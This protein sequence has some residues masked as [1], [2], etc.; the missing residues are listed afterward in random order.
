MKPEIYFKDVELTDLTKAVIKSKWNDAEDRVDIEVFVEQS[1]SIYRGSCSQKSLKEKEAAFE[2]IKSSLTSQEK[3]D[4]V[5]FELEDVKVKKLTVFAQEISD[6]EAIVDIIYLKVNLT[7]VPPEDTVALVMQLVNDVVAAQGEQSKEKTA[8]DQC[9]K[10][11]EEMSK[12]FAKLEAEKTEAELKIYP[13]FLSLL[14]SKKRK[15]A[16]LEKKLH[17]VKNANIPNVSSDF[18]QSDLSIQEA[19]V[20][21]KSP[22]KFSRLIPSSQ[23]SEEPSSQ[24]Q[25]STSKYSSPTRKKLNASINS[26]RSRSQRVTPK[27]QTQRQSLFEFKPLP[28]SGESSEDVDNVTTSSWSP[29]R[30]RNQKVST[31]KKNL[32]E[33]LQ[34]KITQNLRVCDENQSSAELLTTRLTERPR[35][36]SNGSSSSIPAT[37]EHVEPAQ[38][39][40]FNDSSQ[41]RSKD[42]NRSVS[43]LDDSRKEESSQDL[44]KPNFEI[45]TQKYEDDEVPNSQNSESPSIFD[46]YP[47]RK[48]ALPTKSPKTCGKR[49]RLAAS[50]SKFSVDT[51][52][53]LAGL[54]Q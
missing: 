45:F 24:P 12:R 10:D 21:K 25:P 35:K 41:N 52:N 13:N 47:K 36:N 33:G 50:K 30:M 3:Q 7:L 28:E 8:L 23:S 26:P 22:V 20:I 27:S 42:M 38:Q 5:N 39:M 40:E 51:E 9:K 2:T 1:G 4:S 54:S 46:S 32:F 15:I 29:R 6:S 19:Q 34:T 49:T 53:I 18:D 31:K 37:P 44:V 48:R 43:D 11:L 17:M 16:E 14:N